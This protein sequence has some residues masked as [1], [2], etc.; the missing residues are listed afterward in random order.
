MG[1]EAFHPTARAVY[2]KIFI[3]GLIF[4]SLAFALQDIISKFLVD[5]LLILW[6]LLVLVAIISKIYTKFTTVKIEETGL[7]ITKGIL[8]IK[9]IFIQYKNISNVRI[10]Q[11]LFERIIGVGSIGIDTAGTSGTEVIIDYIENEK[12]QRIVQLSKKTG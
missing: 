3:L 11:T 9:K 8:S 4:T 7:T 2:I 1:Q 12:L 5:F 6:T 10:H